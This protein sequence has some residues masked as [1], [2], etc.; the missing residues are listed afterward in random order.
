MSETGGAKSDVI[1][2]EI[3]DLTAL[4]AELPDDDRAEL[5]G[6]IRTLVRFYRAGDAV[7]TPFI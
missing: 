4:L 5:L 6:S 3:A 2:D 1:S 7:R